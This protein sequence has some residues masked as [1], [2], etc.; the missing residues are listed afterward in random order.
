MAAGKTNPATG[1]LVTHQATTFLITNWHVLARRDPTKGGWRGPACCAR[2]LKVHYPTAQGRK[3]ERYELHD[4][5]RDHKWWTLPNGDDFADVAA[6]AV[7]PLASTITL[8]SFAI[9]RDSC[10]QNVQDGVQVDVVGFPNGESHAG[11]DPVVKTGVLER[12][13]EYHAGNCEYF[14][15]EGA[16]TNE[17]MSGS[18]VVMDTGNRTSLAGVY[19]G[20]GKKANQGKGLVFGTRSLQDLLGP[21]KTKPSCRCRFSSG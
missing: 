13:H 16:E 19:A 9:P 20:R 8:R 10:N 21:K 6:L 1:F 11:S 17:G 3:A 14:W 18:P 5:N 2:V 12:T 4:V 7:P 15:I